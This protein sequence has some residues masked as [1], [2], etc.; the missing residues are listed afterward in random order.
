M[1]SDGHTYTIGLMRYLKNDWSTKKLGEFPDSDKWNIFGSMDGVSQQQ[2]GF[3][4]GVFA[5]ILE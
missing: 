1:G 4:C 5:C 3:D 2:T